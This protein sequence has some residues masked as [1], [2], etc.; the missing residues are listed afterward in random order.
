MEILQL[1]TC[2]MSEQEILIE[3]ARIDGCHEGIKRVIKEIENIEAYNAMMRQITSD[4]LIIL[5][6]KLGILVYKNWPRKS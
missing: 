6:D 4:D 5:K 1:D 2:D 3:R